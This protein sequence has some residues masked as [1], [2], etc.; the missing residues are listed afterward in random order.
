MKAFMASL[1]VF[2]FFSVTADAADTRVLPYRYAYEG[3]KA[4][5]QDVFV[6]CDDCPERVIP[7]V[8]FEQKVQELVSVRM[9]EGHVPAGIPMA[10]VQSAI[11]GIQDNAQSRKV[12]EIV[13]ELAM[14]LHF[15]FNRY[16]L[17]EKRLSELD[18]F[19][20]KIVPGSVVSVYGYTCDI[21]QDDYNQRLSEERADAV[22]SFLKA[23]G[24]KIDAVQGRGKSNPVSPTNKRLNRRVEIFITREEKSK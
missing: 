5:L 1:F 4:A 3:A 15:D 8:R 10:T 20:S 16:D 14:V 22:A 12:R 13:P 6:I 19:A 11:T 7:R 21:G 18:R 24:L 17:P 9:P 2:T 23:K